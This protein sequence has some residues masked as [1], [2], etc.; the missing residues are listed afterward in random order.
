MMRFDS[1]INATDATFQPAVLQAPLPAVAVFWSP[2]ETDREKLDTVLE[3]TAE[4]YAGEVL[5]VRL[6][7]ADAP[8]ARAR[9]DVERLPEF[10]FFRDE[11]LIARAKGVPSLKALR[12]WVEYLLGRGTKPTTA[13]PRRKPEATAGD[14]RP[15][16]VTDA[17]FEQV[18]GQADAPVLVDF[19]ASWCGP[20][21]TVAPVVESLAAA[22]AGRAIVAKL[23]VDANQ[24]TARRFAVM[25]VPTLIF[26][27]HG[28]EVDRV[29]GAQPRHVLEQKLEALL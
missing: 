9:Y 29:T 25:S 13:K 22:Y 28:Q 26:F 6:D 3:R 12:P 7:V 20:C 2:E 18:V 4:Q 1:P 11:K 8:E 5:V 16:T 23:D 10:L 17:T 24:A 19:W 15:V 14:G 21:H 27:K